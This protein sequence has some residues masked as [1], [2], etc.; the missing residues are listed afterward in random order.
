[1]DARANNTRWNLGRCWVV[2]PT[3][4][5]LFAWSGCGPKEPPFQP[6]SI[7]PPQIKHCFDTIGH[8][9]G[10]RPWIMGGTCCCTP[11]QELL[12]RHSA[13]GYCRGMSFDQ[14]LAL[15]RSEEIKTALHHKGCNNN[16]EW[17]PHVLWGGKCMVPPTPGTENYEQIA[18]GITYTWELPQ[19]KSSK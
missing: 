12:R 18:S 15:Y 10:A 16:C 4:M 5:W 11:T 6:K 9:S 8:Q 1:M 2:L 13:E 14:L 3:V 7:E 19:R 17:G